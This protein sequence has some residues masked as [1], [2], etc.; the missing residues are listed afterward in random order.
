MGV[1]HL[2]RL[3][4]VAN[5]NFEKRPKASRQIYQIT[6]ILFCSILSDA[7]RHCYWYRKLQ[8]S[9]SIEVI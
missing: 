2:G 8:D 5:L 9:M 1:D 7:I 3:L 4:M 6:G